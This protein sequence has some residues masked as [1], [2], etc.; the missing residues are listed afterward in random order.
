[1]DVLSS[2]THLAFSLN[3]LNSECVVSC[4]FRPKI[5]KVNL[6]CFHSLPIIYALLVPTGASHQAACAL[7]IR[8]EK[9]PIKV[10]KLHPAAAVSNAGQRGR[11]DRAEEDQVTR[12]SF[13][14]NRTVRE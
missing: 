4:N 11:P 14:F 12:C 5:F 8:N 1:M 6:R 9:Q 3:W 2:H 10:S 13:R 7:V